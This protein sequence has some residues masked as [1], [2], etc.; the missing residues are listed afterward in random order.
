MNRNQHKLWIKQVTSTGRLVDIEQYTH[1]E[2]MQKQHVD[3]A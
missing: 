1:I 2:K 3:V